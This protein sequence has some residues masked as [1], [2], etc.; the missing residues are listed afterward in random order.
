MTSKNYLEYLLENLS[1]T[2]YFTTRPM[3]GE[4]LLYLDGKYV[5]LICDNTLLVKQ[6]PTSKALLKD[7]ELLYPY[8]GSKTLMYAVEDIENRKLMTKL[9]EGLFE[10][11]P[12]KKKK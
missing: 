12:D 10:E 6:T 3:M 8:E 5:G 11:L 9:F 2:G 4:Y 1:E 7:C